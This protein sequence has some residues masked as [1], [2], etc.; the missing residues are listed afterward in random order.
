MHGIR[1]TQEATTTRREKRRNHTHNQE[2]E[3]SEQRRQRFPF[4]LG[5]F[6]AC[7]T[8]SKGLVHGFNT[9]KDTLVSRQ[10]KELRCTGWINKRCTQAEK[11]QAKAHRCVS[12]RIP[13][14]FLGVGFV[15]GW[16]SRLLPRT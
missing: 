4:G 15:H 5:S 16:W 1:D 7:T 2:K 12:M 6:A 13:F 3:A 9:P 14:P 8:Q 11:G 10:K